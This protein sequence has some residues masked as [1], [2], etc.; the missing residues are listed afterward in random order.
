MPR[1]K[2]V[3]YTGVIRIHQELIRTMNS[4]QLLVLPLLI[5]LL[6]GCGSSQTAH[7]PLDLGG[8][9]ANQIGELIDMANEA[10]G[11]SVKMNAIFAKG[12]QPPDPQR[13]NQYEYSLG[14]KPSVSGDTAK[15]TVRIDNCK[16][17]EVSH[18]E[19]T[20]VKEGDGWKIQDA[21]LP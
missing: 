5:L 6:G 8:A 19:W 11:N 13:F 12:I 20:F 10:K 14:G 9:D 2:I 18:K 1:F 15:C 4:R 16:S 17:G 21:L 3:C 7:S